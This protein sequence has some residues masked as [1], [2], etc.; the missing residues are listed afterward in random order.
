MQVETVNGLRWVLQAAEKGLSDTGSRGRARGSRRDGAKARLLG[1]DAEG[2]A[3]K[4][5]P[6]S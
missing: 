2:L 1:G 5:F 4:P 3:G 6:P